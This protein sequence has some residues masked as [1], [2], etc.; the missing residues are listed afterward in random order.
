MATLTVLGEYVP[1]GECYGK[2]AFIRRIPHT[3]DIRLYY[4]DIPPMQGWWIGWRLGGEKVWARN[5]STLGQGPPNAEW[6]I[7]WDADFP[8]P[9]LRLV[10]KGFIRV[11][12]WAW[13]EEW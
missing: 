11:D 1:C 9:G 3:I 7:P 2:Q 8:S 12:G 4:W 6:R 13:E 5:T 10:K